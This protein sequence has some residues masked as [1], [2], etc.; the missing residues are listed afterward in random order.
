[1]LYSIKS[2]DD[3]EKLNDLV[4]FQS[5]VKALRFQ[6][7]LGNQNF[8]ED[9]TKLFETVTKSTE[10]ICENVKKNNDGN[11]YRERKSTVDLKRQFFENNE[12]YG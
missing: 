3:L 4:S 5:Q 7:K 10:G 2:R 1:M 11:L 8:H 12:R 9:L 6:D